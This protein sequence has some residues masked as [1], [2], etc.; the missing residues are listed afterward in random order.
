MKKL[1]DLLGD[2]R[3]EEFHSATTPDALPEMPKELE[4]MPEPVPD[5]ATSL[6]PEADV[7]DG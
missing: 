3:G 6:L 4:A 5:N 2:E 1:G 7:T